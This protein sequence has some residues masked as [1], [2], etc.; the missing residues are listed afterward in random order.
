ME[1][2]A[3]HYYTSQAQRLAAPTDPDTTHVHFENLTPYENTRNLE[4]EAGSHMVPYTPMGSIFAKNII[5]R[6]SITQ[7]VELPTEKPRALY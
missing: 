6:D 7:L 5:R 3:A 1:R 2:E 4:T